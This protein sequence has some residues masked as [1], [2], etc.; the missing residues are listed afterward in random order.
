MNAKVPQVRFRA[1]GHD[2]QEIKKETRTTRLLSGSPFYLSDLTFA[3]VQTL[4]LLLIVGNVVAF[5][6]FF[7]FMSAVDIVLIF[8]LDFTT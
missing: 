4:A 3:F 2:S 8:G 7:L 1:R 5:Y 6:G